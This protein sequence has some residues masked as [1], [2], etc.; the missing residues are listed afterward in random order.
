MKILLVSMPSIHF[1]RWAS[2]L[3]D[4]GHEIHWFDILNGGYNKDLKWVTQHTDW[5]YRLG[6]FRGRVFLKKHLPKLHGLLEKNVEIEFERILK[7]VQPDAVHSFVMY[8]CCVPIF[9]VMQRYKN[10]KW[11]YSSWGSD[12]FHFK[13]LPNYREDLEMVLPHIDYLITDNQRDSKIAQELGFRNKFLGS[14][15]GGGGFHLEELEQFVNP[16]SPRNIILVKGYQGRSGRAI[17]VIRALNQLNEDLK[18]YQIVIFGADLEVIN[19]LN[20]LNIPKNWIVYAKLGHLEV[21]K[22]M[23]QAHV[24]IGNSLSDG[25]PN[26]LLEAI[27]MGAFPIQSNPGNATAEIIENGT[28][29]LLIEDAENSEEIKKL[30]LSALTND[31]L[32][33]NAF[34][35]N[36]E[37]KY[38]LGFELIKE[39]VLKAYN[40]IEKEL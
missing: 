21:L 20:I 7:V 30:I 18:E 28:N 3:K 13:N 34:D 1:T 33:K 29:G 25:M 27:I 39:Q 19:Y 8:K 12:L 32:I 26:T 9:P 15:P 23:G 37:L 36:Q 22:T 35:I 5:R 16:V 17:P 31:S 11:I 2:Q 24:Y 40:Q 6:D 10:I 4:A 14:F 38:S